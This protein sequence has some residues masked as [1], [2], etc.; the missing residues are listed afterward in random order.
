[1]RSVPLITKIHY[2]NKEKKEKPEELLNMTNE[3][4]MLLK[5]KI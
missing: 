4:K 2:P 1:M 3:E 5:K